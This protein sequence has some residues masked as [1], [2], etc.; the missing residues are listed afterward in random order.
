[1]PSTL[2][3]PY[4]KTVRAKE[5]L[6]ELRERLKTFRESNP[7]SVSREE[8]VKNGL[9]VLRFEIKDIPDKTPLIVGDFV[10]CLRCAL[11]QLVWALAKEVG[12]YPH[13]T[14]FPIFKVANPKRFSEYILGVPADANAIIESL[15]PYHARDAEAIAS[16]YLQQLSLL[17]NIDKHRRIPV[18]STVICF[19]F[20]DVPRGLIPHIR[21]DREAKVVIVPLA[22]KDYMALDPVAPIDITF[23]DSYEGIRCNFSRLEEI[24]EFVANS[25]IP[26]FS[27]FF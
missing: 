8:D 6:D 13:G 14:Q 7:G 18:E 26:R 9:Y 17:C 23:G 1:M 4:L 25:V 21:F 27:R 3:D 11:D 20:P 2:S 24:Y 22:L 19:R 15:Q 10:Y 16:H 5:H 12:T